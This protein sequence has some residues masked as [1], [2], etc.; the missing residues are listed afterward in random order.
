[1]RCSPRAHGDVSQAA[2]GTLVTL[3]K[4]Y[5]LVEG[6]LSNEKRTD[7]HEI[8]QRFKGDAEDQGWSLRVAKVI[9]L[10]E[11]LR[12]LPRTESNIAAFLVDE[13]G[14]PAPLAP[15][16]AAVKR[17]QNAQFIRNTE[18]GW[19][20]QTAQEKNWETERRSYLEPKPRERNEITR[21]VLEKIF[22]EAEFK[23]YRYQNLRTFRIGIT[24]EGTHLA[25]EGE[26]P[27]SLCIADDADDLTRKLGE[28][29]EESRQ[30]SHSGNVYWVFG[31]T[32]EIDELVAQLHA[33]RRMVEK[34]DQL[35][36]QNK[37]CIR[38][39]LLSSGRENCGS[40]A[41]VP[42]E[43]QTD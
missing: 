6:N 13:V 35:R 23:T 25:D 34:Y 36:A 38:R 19:K 28:V 37:I 21:Q 9:C 32:T 7:I 18:E 22:D 24:V 15:V 31:L 20:L 29:R 8:A 33:S 14:Q 3:D 43:R 1:M 42:T 41:P 39:R 5:E 12:D 30:P 4:V 27:L 40:H 2:V 10:L 17:L 26:L 11:F 16:Q